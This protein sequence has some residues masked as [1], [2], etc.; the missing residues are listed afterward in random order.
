MSNSS[1]PAP[2]RL[3]RNLIAGAAGATVLGTGATLQTVWAQSASDYPNKP[4][5]LV[6]GFA[7]GGPTDITARAIGDRKSV[8]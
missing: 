5:K 6:L 8:V 1:S 3:R 7:T 4:V 2:S